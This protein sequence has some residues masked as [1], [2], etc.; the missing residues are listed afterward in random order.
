M[1][2]SALRIMS[3]SLR[4]CSSRKARLRREIMASPTT[5]MVMSPRSAS[6]SMGLSFH[7]QY[8]GS[9]SQFAHVSS[10]HAVPSPR[11]APCQGSRE[12][13]VPPRVYDTNCMVIRRSS[14]GRMLLRHHLVQELRDLRDH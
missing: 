6:Y 14:S 11:R 8:C 13:L 9:V 10:A 3:M 5:A 1:L 2:T 12:G 7:E 4:K